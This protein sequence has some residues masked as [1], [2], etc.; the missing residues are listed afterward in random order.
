MWTYWEEM[1]AQGQFEPIMAEI[2][3]SEEELKFYFGADE[4]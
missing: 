4:A 3:E 2:R 1:E